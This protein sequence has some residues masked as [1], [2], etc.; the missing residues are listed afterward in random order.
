MQYR[1]VTDWRFEAPV[2]AVWA[3]ILTSTAWPRWW[4][5]VEE[6]VEL[7]PGDIDGLDNVRRYTFRSVLPYALAFELRTT[8]IEPH[9]LVE[10]EAT[11]E[12]RGTGRWVV[13]DVGGAT[14]ARFVWEVEPGPR[15]MRALSPFLRPV[16]AWNHD[17][18]M[19]WGYEGARREL[20]SAAAPTAVAE[21]GS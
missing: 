21:A 2:D 4:R 20:A 14:V 13:R 3:L 8:R 19:R 7:E 11:G 9:V 12:L 1:F 10:A 15:W 5:G 6:V 18:I 16:F 17:V